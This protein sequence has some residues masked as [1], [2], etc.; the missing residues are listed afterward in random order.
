MRGDDPRDIRDRAGHANFSTTEGYIRRGRNK[1]ELGDP[2]P[3]LPAN[4]V[5]PQTVP[6]DV[7]E[8]LARGSGSWGPGCSLGGT[9]VG[10][11]YRSRTGEG[12][13]IP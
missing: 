10:T 3:V 2:F 4:V 5:R 6:G 7:P 8:S 9:G 13:V 11:T 12:I 1:Q